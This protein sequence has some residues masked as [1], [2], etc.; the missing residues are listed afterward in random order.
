MSNKKDLRVNKY[1][2]YCDYSIDLFDDGL[3]TNVEIG[4]SQE[5]E[6]VEL[7]LRT[8]PMMTKVR[9]DWKGL[10]KLTLLMNSALY[11]QWQ[12]TTPG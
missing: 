11:T 2:R 7:T 4:T 12:E 5:S 6:N 9:L 1:G 3:R 8:G 10:K